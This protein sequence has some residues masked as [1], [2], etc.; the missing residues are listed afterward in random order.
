MTMSILANNIY[1]IFGLELERYQLLTA[2]SLYEKFILNEGDIH[3]DNDKIVVKLKKKRNL[4]IILET[5]KKY[6]DLSYPWLKGKKI[7]FEGAAY[8]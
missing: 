6:E 2:Q 5:M 3:I 1:R 7:H 4:P 8:S